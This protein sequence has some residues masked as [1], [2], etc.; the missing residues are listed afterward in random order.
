MRAAE[1]KE[2]VGV[3]GPSL[4]GVLAPQKRRGERCDPGHGEIHRVDISKIRS[5]KGCIVSSIIIHI[6][7][8]LNGSHLFAKESFWSHF[9]HPVCLFSFSSI[10]LR[11]RSKTLPVPPEPAQLRNWVGGEIV[12]AVEEATGRPASVRFGSGSVFPGPSRHLVVPLKEGT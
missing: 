2:V 12:Q 5:S 1:P 9:H 8:E 3:L 11:V 4:R 6:C 7:L 10:S